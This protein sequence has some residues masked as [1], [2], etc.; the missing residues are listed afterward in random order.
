[1]RKSELIKVLNS[2]PENTEIKI[3]D[4]NNT[5][6]IFKSIQTREIIHAGML[7]IPETGI[8][9]LEIKR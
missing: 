1:M 5:V 3:K 7:D 6:D 9:L 2:M 8:L 4:G